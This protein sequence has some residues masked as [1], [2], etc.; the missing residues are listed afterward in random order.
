[1]QDIQSHRDYFSPLAG[2]MLGRIVAEK[3]WVFLD[4]AGK[5]IPEINHAE[6]WDRLYRYTLE[7]LPPERAVGRLKEFTAYFS[8]NFVF[9]HELHKRCLRARKVHEVREAAMHFLDSN[10]QLAGQGA[11]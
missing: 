9:G 8:N 1:M 6:I 2:L 10:P 5:P 7:D 11:G 3:P 4:F